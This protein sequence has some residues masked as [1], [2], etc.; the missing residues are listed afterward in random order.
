MIQIH[1]F[2]TISG[3]ALTIG[4]NGFRWQLVLMI[5][6]ACKTL[7]LHFILLHQAPS[8]RISQTPLKVYDPITSSI[9]MAF[10]VSDES[11]Y[12]SHYPSKIWHAIDVDFKSYKQKCSESSE[13]VLTTIIAIMNFRYVFA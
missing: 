13:I 2:H 1:I 8:H 11:S 7:D 9:E 3:K 6:N 12:F 5:V 4:L 10:L